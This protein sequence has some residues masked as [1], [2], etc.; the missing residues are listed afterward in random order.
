M[1]GK[2]PT[3]RDRVK[4]GLPATQNIDDILRYDK[5][6]HLTVTKLEPANCLELMEKSM[7]RNS[8]EDC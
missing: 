1:E 5:T 2:T 4:H 8:L 6:A 7:L 3:V